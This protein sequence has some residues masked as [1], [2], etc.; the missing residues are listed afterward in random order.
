[1]ST[2]NIGFNE[3]ISKIIPYLSSNIIKYTPV[4]QMLEILFQYVDLTMG[5][6]CPGKGK[7]E[8]L[9]D[10]YQSIVPVCVDYCLHLDR[11]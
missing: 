6:L 7:I 5:Q 8:E 4:F 9:E 11:M 10:Y 1:M 3:E 2:H